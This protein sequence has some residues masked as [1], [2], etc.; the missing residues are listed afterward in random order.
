MLA[1][2]LYVQF[3]CAGRVS[4]VIIIAGYI[5][6]LFNLQHP[7]S[8]SSSSS[9]PTRH[10]PTLRPSRKD[11]THEH[12]SHA[13][14]TLQLH[15]IFWEMEI[16]FLSTRLSWTSDQLTGICFINVK[17]MLASAWFVVRS[18][19]GRSRGLRQRQQHSGHFNILPSAIESL[20]SVHFLIKSALR[21]GSARR[22]GGGKIYC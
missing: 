22:R 11:V 7:A 6:P 15:L 5:R 2:A 19:W 13:A 3:C 17:L 8:S 18:R 20:R 12:L 10:S 14:T 16:Y 9:Q 4:P 21:A 1:S